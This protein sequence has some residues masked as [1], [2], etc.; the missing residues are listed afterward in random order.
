[1]ATTAGWNATYYIWLWPNRAV[2]G[3]KPDPPGHI[4]L[5]F[6]LYVHV[7]KLTGAHWLA[8]Q[9]GNQFCFHPM[10]RLS[11]FPNG[12]LLM[13]NMVV[14]KN[15]SKY[16]SSRPQTGSWF[17]SFMKNVLHTGCPG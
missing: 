7:Y 12:L 14:S 1:M 4:I 16:I 10:H 11:G 3:K 6:I 9:S 2:M 5:A 13:S 15:L 8:P 17:R